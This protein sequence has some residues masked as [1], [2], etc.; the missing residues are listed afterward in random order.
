MWS[1][2]AEATRAGDVAVRAAA[3]H[4]I[5]AVFGGVRTA[6][7]AELLAGSDGMCWDSDQHLRRFVVAE[8][9]TLW[10]SSQAAVAAEER[11]PAAEQRLLQPLREGQRCM[12]SACVELLRRDPSAVVRREAATF[13]LETLPAG[14]DTA[15]HLMAAVM[16][17]A[18]DKDRAVRL[19]ALRH[20]AQMDQKLLCD[21]L[22]RQGLLPRVM[23]HGL[24]CD[25]TRAAAEQLLG[26]IIANCDAADAL[27]KMR[28]DSAEALFEPLLRRELRKLG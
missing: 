10:R 18:V 27:A 16:H 22:W 24:K 20:M 1:T 19:A 5:L 12:L 26:A 2:L 15:P 14:G 7:V 21:S 8:L 9:R 23:Q 25:G 28:V 13:V 6:K 17:A 3:S 4:A 11:L